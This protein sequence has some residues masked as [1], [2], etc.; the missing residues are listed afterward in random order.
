MSERLAVQEA[1]MENEFLSRYFDVEM[2]EGFLPMAVPSSRGQDKGGC[3]SK[4]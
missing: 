3:L 4:N 1:I 2:W